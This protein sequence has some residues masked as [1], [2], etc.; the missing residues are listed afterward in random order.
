MSWIGDVVAG[1]VGGVSTGAAAATPTGAIT[2][3]ATVAGKVI[4]WIHPDPSVAAEIKLKLASQEGQQFLGELSTIAQVD[5]AQADVN[6]AD[7]SSGNWFQAGWRPA[8]GW[9]CVFALLYQFVGGPFLGWILVN[10]AGW[11]APP[12]LATDSLITL[13]FGIL[14]LGAYRMSEK[15]AGVAP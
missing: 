12:S 10:S 2:A 3:V 14:G 1:A 11:T 6:R 9:V 7:A 4:D 15:K 13:L 8:A 5:V